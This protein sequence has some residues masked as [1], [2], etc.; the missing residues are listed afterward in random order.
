MWSD[1]IGEVAP[2]VVGGIGSA[3]SSRNTRDMADDNRFLSS[4]NRDYANNAINQSWG[5]ISSW[6]T[7]YLEAGNQGLADYRAQSGMA[8]DAPVFADFNQGDEFNFDYKNFDQNPAYQFRMDQ[9]LQATNRLQ[10]ANKNLGSGNRL[11]ATQ[12]YAQGLATTEYENA[13]N[14]QAQT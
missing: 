3:F 14:R 13:F 12:D 2:Y 8:P 5:D 9:G 1:V 11:T 4:A 7:P 10:A 6:L